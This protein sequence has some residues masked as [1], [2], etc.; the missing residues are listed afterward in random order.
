MKTRHYSIDQLV[1]FTLLII[2]LIS[3]PTF[4]G[5]VVQEYDEPAKKELAIKLINCVIFIQGLSERVTSS[6]NPQAIS[7]LTE[8]RALSR[9]AIADYTAGRY[10]DTVVKTRE[11]Y[12]LGLSAIAILGKDFPPTE[13]EQQ[14]GLKEE[15]NRRLELQETY[16][17]SIKRTLGYLFTEEAAAELEI[18]KASRKKSLDYY[19]AE[20]YEDAIKLANESINQAIL[21]ITKLENIEHA[22]E[23][24]KLSVDE[25]IE[26]AQKGQRELESMQSK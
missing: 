19:S 15:A 22:K 8:A 2:A 4:A 25:L 9:G 18:I 7:E 17:A 11:A 10:G 14:A 13:E 1:L 26:K 12:R 21:T 3:V 23:Q 6:G 20:K 5:P 16:I 24:H